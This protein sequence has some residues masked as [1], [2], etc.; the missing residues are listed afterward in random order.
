MA[1]LPEVPH[2]RLASRNSRNRRRGMLRA[3]IYMAGAAVVTG[4]SAEAPL[5]GQPVRLGWF[6]TANSLPARSL[7]LNVGTIQTDPNVGTGTGNQLYFGGGSY[8]L[9]DRLSF[10]VDLQSYQDPPVKPIN[11]LFP[12]FVV[13]T[14]AFWAKYKVYDGETLSVATQVSA[15]TFVRLE[16]PVFG[17]RYD[18]VVIGSLKAPITYK[19]SERLQFHVTPSVSFLP[20]TVGGNAFYGTVA[21]LGAGVSF[22]ATERLG[23][24]GAVDV[25]VSGSNTISNTATFIAKPV[26]VAGGRYLITPKIALDAYVTNSVGMTP[27]TSILTHWPDGDMVLA[28]ARLTWTPGSRYPESFRG[29]PN[30][31]TARHRNLQIDGFTVGS[32]DTLEPGTVQASGWY[33]TDAH[34]GVALNFSLDRDTEIDLIYENYAEDGTAPAALVPTTEPRYMIGPKLRFMDQNNGDAYSLSGRMLYG[35]QI[36]PGVAGVGVFYLE[37]LASYKVND[38]LVLSMNP[39]LA[40]FGNT[41]IAGVGFG[42]NYE[43]LDGLDLIAEATAVGLDA[44]TP[45][46]AVGA[47]YN[48]PNTGLSVDATATNAIGRYGIGT[49]VAQDNTKFSIGVTKRFN[50]LNWR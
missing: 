25:P 41:E 14:A 2:C 40:G 44:T 8:A 34:S 46:W 24:Y 18:G 33:G 26:W 28:G 35:R 30:P 11:G 38:R 23:F 32:A 5:S 9:S 12:D 17:G 10:G 22:A 29:V 15:E 6:E 7:E 39:Q 1:S 21:S 48:L 49:M 3:A 45:T 20:E 31:V 47:R 50:V 43:L 36:E 4:A 37:I 19:A 27:A 16:S 13:N 42:V